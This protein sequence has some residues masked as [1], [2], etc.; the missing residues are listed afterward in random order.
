MAQLLAQ[1]TC[2]NCRQPFTAP[3]EQVL[4]VEI[5]PSA[6]TRL[7]SGQVNLVGCPHCGMVGALPVPFMYHDPAKELA[8]V[9]MPMEAGR[10]D[11]E[12]QQAIGSLSRAVLNALPQEQR[13][14]YLLNPQ[15]FFTYESL[16][17]RVLEA[18]GVTPE[19]IQAQRNK[20]A[21]LKRLLEAPTSEERAALVGENEALLDM[22]FFHLL[23]ANLEQADA[24]G[25]QDLVQRLLEVRTLLFERTAVGRRLAARA[26]AL[27]ALQAQPTRERLVQLLTSSDDPETRAALIAFGQPLVDYAFFQAIT[28]RIEAAQEESERRRLESIRKEVLDVRQAIQEQARQVVEERAGLLRDLVVSDQPELLARRHL[29][30]FD[31][32]FFS[33][34]ATEIDQAQKQGEAAIASRLQDIWRLTMGLVQEQVPPELVLLTRVLEASGTEEV[35]RVLEENRQLVREPFLQLLQQVEQELRQRGEDEAANQAALSLSIART[36]TS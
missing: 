20:A 1:I 4:D 26:E 27:R 7:L 29:A 36:M 14:G 13:K 31:D 6:K 12:R 23:Q 5:D 17:N 19:M 35:R 34:L 3:L 15:V 18:D 22:E 10:T 28:Q 24:M 25:R 11:L 21:L 33:V 16:V 30:E 8:L 9:F 2:P 32:L